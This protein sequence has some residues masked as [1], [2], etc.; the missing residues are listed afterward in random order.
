MLHPAPPSDPRQGQEL[1]P[2]L[3][4]VPEDAQHARGDSLAVDLL[5]AP[6]H[7]AHVAG[8]HHHPD[9]RGLHR[10]HYRHG[11]LARQPLLEIN[12]VFGLFFFFVGN[13]FSLPAVAA[14]VS[15]SPLS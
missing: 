10:L 1:A 12:N 13:S 9:A 8:L 4:V 5:H 7:H 14:S 3:G 15:I 6:H 11:D 2:G